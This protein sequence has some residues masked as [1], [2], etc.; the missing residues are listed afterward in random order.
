[1]SRLAT[2]FVLGY[3]GCDEKV[4]TKAIAGEIDLLQSERDFDWLGP[5]SYFWESDP[6]RALEWAH[7]KAS[8]GDYKEPV[9]VGAV[10]D[11]RNCLDLVNREDL[12]LVKAA[13]TAFVGVQSKAGLPVPKNKSVPGAP[14]PDRILRYLDCAV[15]RHLH[16]IL[17]AKTDDGLAVEP[18]DTVRGMFIEGKKLYPGS[19]FKAHSHAQIAVRNKDCILGV[20]RPR[21]YPTL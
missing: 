15:I 7:W 17:D 6:K 12:E 5:G 4:A 11:L 19:G 20:F 8:R 14:N 9:V 1:L 13:Y 3:H 10:I 18:F 2:S 21:P 16:S